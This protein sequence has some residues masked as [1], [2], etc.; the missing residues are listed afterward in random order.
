MAYEFRQSGTSKWLS[1]SQLLLPSQEIEATVLFIIR[2][3]IHY[4]QTPIT[5]AAIPEH[6]RDIVENAVIGIFQA[7]LDGKYIA[8]N[9]TL[10]QIYGYESPQSLIENI[11]DIN[12]QL[13]TNPQRRAVFE[14]LIQEV[15]SVSGFESQICRQDKTVIWILESTR[16]VFD[17]CGVPLYYEGFVQEITDQKQTEAELR[18]S[19]ERYALALSLIHI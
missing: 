18:E 6:Y 5:L 12:T 3:N 1:I 14:H 13:Y 16:L 8:A 10:A 2:D 19:E 17:E 4:L 11:T 7:S 9:L 15:G